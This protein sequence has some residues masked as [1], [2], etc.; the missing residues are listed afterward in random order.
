[1]NMREIPSREWPAFLDKLGREHRAWLA[2]VDRSGLVEAREQPLVSISTG[3][4]I[5]IRIGEKAI[6]VDEPQAVRVEETAEGATQALQIDD[7]TGRRLTLRFRVAVA[8]G[9]L[10]GL[11][12]AER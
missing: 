10:D 7:A 12:P 9:A 3:D 4:G 5:D 1:M 11:A 2:T 8:P 6:H